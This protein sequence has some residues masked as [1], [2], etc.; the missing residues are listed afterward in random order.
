MGHCQRTVAWLEQTEF[1]RAPQIF[2]V[3]AG[4]MSLVGPRAQPATPDSHDERAT[5][6]QR[7]LK[8]GVIGPWSVWT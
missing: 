2:H 6:N 7:T 4:Q 1:D 5:R 3:V 8:P